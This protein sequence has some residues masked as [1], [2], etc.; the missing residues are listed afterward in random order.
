[1]SCVPTND[2]APLSQPD[3][4]ALTT[5]IQRVLAALSEVEAR[6]ESDRECLK[7]WSGPYAIRVRFVE[8]LEAHH[9]QERQPLV[10]R[11][12]DLHQQITTAAM[13]QSL[14]SSQHKGTEVSNGS[15]RVRPSRGYRPRGSSQWGA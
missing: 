6:Y 8:H 14:R 5:E 1:M 3:R 4:G 13:L 11:L 7:G 10:Q 9:A 15:G 2:P 12:A